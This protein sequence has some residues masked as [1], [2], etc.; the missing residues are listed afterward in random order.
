MRIGCVIS[1][2]RH[3]AW[4]EEC[5]FDYLEIKGDFLL[6]LSRAGNIEKLLGLE[7]ISFEA[8]T[9]PLP[10]GL[11]AR[12]VGD[13]ADHT[14]ALKVFTQMV[15]LSATLG[16]RKIVLGSGQARTVPKHFKRDWAYEQLIDFINKA[17]SV[18]IE[19]KQMLSIEPL[20]SG[21]TNL[22]N[23]CI[24]A[25][26]VVSD[27]P[28]V[29]I[30]ADCYH[31]FTEQLSVNDELYK[32]KIMHAHTSYLPR[33]SGIFREKY[34]RSFLKKLQSIGC[35]DISIEEIFD[36]KR[37]MHEMLLKIRKLSSNSAG[38]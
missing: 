11:G 21:E 6:Q 26:K 18:C 5:A 32:S 31:I 35:N 30:T 9:S 22:I 33:G 2:S 10:R 27:I 34:Q 4:T 37:N 29:S 23:S 3:L 15:D 13:D 7:R 25:Q 28:E 8:M 36:S 16:V 14:Y 38:G 12:I 24:E 19:R 1:D 20:H 17:K